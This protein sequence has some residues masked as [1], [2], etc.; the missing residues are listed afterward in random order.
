MFRRFRQAD[1]SFYDRGMDIAVHPLT[2]SDLS[3]ADHICRIAFGTFLGLPNP[4]AFMGD[5]D[6]VRTRWHADPEAAFGAFA[7]G[8]LA[9]SI[10]AANWGSIGF[11]GPLT[12]RPEL[13]DRGIAKRLLEPVIEAFDGWG[14]QVAGLFT[15]P[16]SQKHIGL[17]QRF[18][19]WPRFLT[20][21]TSKAVVPATSDR[22]DGWTLFSDVRSGDHERVLA[23]C[24][25]LTHAIYDGFDVTIDIRSVANQ[26][27]GDTLLLWRDEGLAGIAVC[28]CGAG[29][30][31]GTGTCYVKFAGVRPGPTDLN[32]FD[33][34]LDACEAFA[35]L[36]SAARLKAGVNT[37]R[38]EAYARML[39]RGFRTDMHGIVMQ[40]PNESGYNRR[41]VF[42][43]DDWR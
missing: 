8:E 7:G 29:S 34:L 37:A 13:W 12:I 42:V 4:A 17:Y 15:F 25:D 6:Y 43:I 10:F 41:G 16:H 22:T 40:R 28:H 20:A 3:T 11:F 32:D 35:S 30:E 39:Q 27:L 33:R 36:R 5:A 26:R 24:R 2:E 9:G 1:D 14:T 21:M 23:E 31:A 19:F 18:G 38:Q